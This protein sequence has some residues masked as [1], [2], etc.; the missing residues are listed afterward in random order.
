MILSSNTIQN[1]PEV[2]YYK[3]VITAGAPILNRMNIQI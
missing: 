2:S 1:E 3:L